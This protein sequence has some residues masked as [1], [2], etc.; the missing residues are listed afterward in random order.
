MLTSGISLE[1]W[2]LQMP[3]ALVSVN[4]TV[5]MSRRERP[6]PS[7]LLTTETLPDVMVCQ[8]VP[9]NQRHSRGVEL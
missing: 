7:S 5:R 3:V 2:Y 8:I 4:G 9:F 1:A 6:T